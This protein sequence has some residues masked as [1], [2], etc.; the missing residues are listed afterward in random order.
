[1]ARVADH[2]S[3]A[4]LEQRFRSCSDPV[5][6][7]HPQVIW[8]LAQGRTFGA[9]SE[10]TSFGR[11]WIEQLLERYDAAHLGL[12]R[13]LPQRGWEAL[14]AIGWSLQRPRPKNPKSA[15]PEEAPAF[16]KV[17]GCRRRRSGRPS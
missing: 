4:D 17:G 8:L 9:R 16:E 15:T 2:A 5:E 3:V 14:N 11:R 7:R 10:V 13:V 6:A 12:E 1:M